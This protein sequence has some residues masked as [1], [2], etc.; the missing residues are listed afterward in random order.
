MKMLLAIINSD[1]AHSVMN[2]LMEAGFQ[3]TKLATT[4]GFLRA[5]NVTILIGLEDS[6]LDEAMDLIRKYSNTRKQII[7][8]TANLGVGFHPAMPVE[9][10]VGG[11]TVFVLNVEQFEK[12]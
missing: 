6:R 3:I 1:D 11:A 8:T 4:G 7:P 5:G 9:V 12:L 10:T 2:H